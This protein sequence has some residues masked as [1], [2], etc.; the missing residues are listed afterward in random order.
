MCN[1]CRQSVT[2]T[3]GDPETVGTV[4]HAGEQKEGDVGHVATPI[5]AALVR[6]PG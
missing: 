2:V 1:V 6:D 4:L 3:G 5:V